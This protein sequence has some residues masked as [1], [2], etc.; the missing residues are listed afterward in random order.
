VFY[1]PFDVN[2]KFIYQQQYDL[3]ESSDK[4][5]RK[6]G[7]IIQPLVILEV[8]STLGGSSGSNIQG[9]LKTLYGQVQLEEM[10][11][12]CSCTMCLSVYSYIY[13]L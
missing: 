5:G 2:K 13:I 12:L 8:S 1:E 4:F 3:V 6:Y 7:R 10:V 9:Y 11:S